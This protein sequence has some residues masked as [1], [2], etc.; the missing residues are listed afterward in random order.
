MTSAD[1]AAFIHVGVPKSGT[2]FLQAALATLRPAL[3]SS[4]VLYPR[5]GPESMFRAAVDIRG[6]PQSWGRDS[7]DVDGTWDALCRKAR[8]FNGRT[9]ISHELLAGAPEWQAD[10]ALSKLGDLEVHVIVTAR[11]LARQVTAEWQEGIK[12]GRRVTFEEFRTRILS[13]SNE[14]S[15]A[16][17]FWSSQDLPDVLARWGAQLPPERV[18]V[19]CC[20]PPGSDRKML[21]RRF[22]DAVG[23]DPEPFE[24]D[25][26]DWNNP[27]LGT[28]QID[29]LRRVNGALDGRL[30]QPAY[31][32]V[33]KRYFAQKVLPRYPSPR[34]VVPADMYD[35]LVGL[36]KHWVEH[37]EQ[38]GYTVHGDLDELIP[39]DPPDLTAPHPD[40]VD[41][42]GVVD[43][44]AS[45]IADLL[46]DLAD[47]LP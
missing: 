38:A 40:V 2:T 42:D 19:V 47:E 33:V 6:N 18:H 36:G 13:E 3:R 17:R 21:W 35:V 16:Q 28:V 45:V 14:H 46:V 23:F 27:S 8:D 41:A 31:G 30:V 39:S 43:A 20:P 5:V 9:V 26:P 44:A 4:G 24:P 22:A 29:L 37:I 10:L 25:L 1:R 32:R 34:A 15:H 7:S 12:H 11:D